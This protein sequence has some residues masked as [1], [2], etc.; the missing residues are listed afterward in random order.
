MHIAEGVL[1]PAILVGGAL[2]T[3][4][5]TAMGLKRLRHEDLMLMALMAAAF[6]VASLI[7]VPIGP[8]SAHLILNGALGMLLGWGAFPAILMG[9]ALQALFFQYGG[10]TVLG[11]NTW[12]MA[13]PAVFLGLI[14]RPWILRPGRARAMAAFVCGFGSVLGAGLLTALS[15]TFTDEGF[16]RAAQILFLAHLPVAVAEGVVTALLVRFLARVRPETFG[17]VSP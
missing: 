3:A 7:H 5:G 2:L 1:S 10:L 17:I 11:I 13:A 9:L 14:A 15:L 8:T 4:G 6:F 12:N 16:L